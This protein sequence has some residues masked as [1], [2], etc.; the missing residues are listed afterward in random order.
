MDKVQR[1][2]GVKMIQDDLTREKSGLFFI[3]LLGVVCSSTFLGLFLSIRDDSISKKIPYDTAVILTDTQGNQY[4]V[5]YGKV[6]LSPYLYSVS[7]PKIPVG[8]S[9]LLE[10]A[11]GNKFFVEY[12]N[13]KYCR[14]KEVIEPKVIK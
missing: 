14:I 12:Y 7:G 4:V 5:Q 13:E 9:L 8:S 6:I 10:D 3:I 11:V 2:M 1:E